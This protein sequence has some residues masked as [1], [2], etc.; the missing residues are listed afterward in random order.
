MK[1]RLRT[2]E[3]PALSLY[4]RV[5]PGPERQREY[6]LRARAA[7]ERLEV[8]DRVRRKALR[9]VDAD[10]RAGTL[11]LFA[12]ET[13]LEVIPLSA[14]LPLGDAASGEVEAHWGEPYLA[15]L[16]LALGGRWRYGVIH[17]DD[18]FARL[19]EVFLEEIELCS[20]FSR[21]QEGSAGSWQP[22][23]TSHRIDARGR[24]AAARDRGERH[25]DEIRQSFYREVGRQIRSALAGRGIEVVIVVGPDKDVSDF[26]SAVP[27]ELTRRTTARL[28]ALSRSDAGPAQL[29]EHVAETIRADEEHRSDALLDEARERGVCGADASLAALQEGRLATLLVAWDLDQRLRASAATGRLQPESVEDADSGGPTVPPRLALPH[30]AWRYSTDVVFVDGAPGS[31]LL[32]ELGGIAGLTRW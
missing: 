27:D 19:F 9:V 22:G 30:L 23:A 1:L 32:D 7:L 21:A 3:P 6:V 24:D 10:R 17:L 16:L 5:H 8:P 15:P 26:L 14:E 31:R 20:G 18:R 13:D 11:I 28:P 25:R 12:S 2:F 4:L 29:L